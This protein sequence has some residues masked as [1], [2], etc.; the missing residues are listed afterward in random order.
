YALDLG[1]GRIC[2]FTNVPT[3]KSDTSEPY[4]LRPMTLDDIP[5]AAALF[6]R[7]AA[8]ALVVCP[9]PQWLWQHMLTGRSP[10]SIEYTPLQ[11]IETTDGR[12]VGYV[13]PSREI[14]RDMT[15][16]SELSVGEGQSLR[17][18]MPSVL[19][20]LQT[21]AEAEAGKQNKPVHGVYLALGK[22]HP[23][24]N[25]I[26]E[27]L[28]TAWRV[29]GWYLRVADMPRFIRHIAPVLQARLAQSVMAGYTGDLKLSEYTRGYRLAFENGKL[30]CAEAWQPTE[31]ESHAAFPPR[32]LLQLLFGF[33]SLG[34][35]RD[36][37]AD[38]SAK[39]EAD[40][41]LNALFP[42][43]SSCVVPV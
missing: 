27:L 14:W 10:E 36:F 16:V 32:V 35:L 15:P 9:R 12:A 7:D 34:E 20:W 13:M 6:E 31:S 43:Q 26:P 24:F 11:V 1:G 2:Y 8:R 30:T 4:R 28:P 17:A 5:F 38:C 23:V 39:D 37:Y 22:E 29:Y 33:R 25:A 41:L 42:K 40:V 19:R 18:V 3:L 21:H